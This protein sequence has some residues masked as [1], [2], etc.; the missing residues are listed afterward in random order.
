MKMTGAE[1][2]VECIRCE[3]VGH[4]FCVPGESYLS[5]IDA[6]YEEEAVELISSRHEGGAAFAAEAY[7]KASGSPGVCLVT[8]GP[9]ACNA[10]IGVHT[11]RQDSTPLVLFIGQVERGAYYR[12]GFQEVDFEAFFR[13]LAKWTLEVREARRVPELV[14]RAFHVARS[15]RPGPVVVSLPEDMLGETADMDFT[16]AY[17]PTP[18]SLSTGDARAIVRELADATEAV[19]IAG[20][21]VIRAGARS[22]LVE[23]SE[24]MNLPVFS[25]FRRHDVFPNHHSHYLG[26]LGLKISPEQRQAIREAEVVFAIGTRLSEITTQGYTLLSPHQ[27]LVHVDIDPGVFGVYKSSALAATADAR[28]A[29]TALLDASRVLSPGPLVGRAAWISKYRQAYEDYTNPDS[30]ARPRDG[31]V[32]AAGMMS[33]AMSALPEDSIITVDAGN[34]AGWVQRFYQFRRA[35]TFVGPTSGAMGY[36]V[37]AALGAKLAHPDRTV[38]SFS[39]DGGFMMTLGEIETAVRNRVPFVSVVV[40]NGMYGTI[41]M[42]QEMHFPGRVH[43]TPLSDTD[44]AAVAREFGAHG[45]KVT[46]TDDFL[47][48][49]KRAVSSALGSGKPAIVEV[50][51]DPDQITVADTIASLRKDN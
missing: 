12:E 7:A 39:G 13:P 10:S 46:K 26:H 51:T 44:F 21:G 16:D 47:E 1:A 37:P 28:H 50:M 48:A 14:Q 8:R 15:G 20:G 23:L 30:V 22:Q 18:P 11:A 43:A 49:L 9:G 34:F 29:L 5:V 6:L 19:V 40:N 36:G 38:V 32:D 42:H 3:S 31:Y 27:R 2:V 35:G 25:A 17:T 33:L 41:R 45:E 4:V 24:R